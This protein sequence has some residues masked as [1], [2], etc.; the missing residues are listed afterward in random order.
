[1]P[2]HPP[3][4]VAERADGPGGAR[5]AAGPAGRGEPA[6][7]PGAAGGLAA[8]SAGGPATGGPAAYKYLS[9][10]LSKAWDVCYVC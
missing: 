7:G 3:R 6:D 2:R 8:G 9:V 5:R 10:R 4:H 1:M